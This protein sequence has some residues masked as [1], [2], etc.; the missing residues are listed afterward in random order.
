MSEIGTEVRIWDLNQ[1]QKSGKI[2]SDGCVHNQD[3]ETGTEVRIWDSGQVQ[4]SGII[5]SD[6]C[7]HTYLAEAPAYYLNPEYGNGAAS[8]PFL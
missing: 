6:G 1:V 5:L 2:L 8:F 7:V 4:K 3:A